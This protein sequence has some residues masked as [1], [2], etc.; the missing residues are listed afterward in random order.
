V[1]VQGRGLRYSTVV[2]IF[3]RLVRAMGIHQG[4][5]YQGP[6]IHDLRHSFAVRVLETSSTMTCPIDMGAQ[7]LALSTYL[8]HAELA[9]TYWYIHATPHL[10]TE[11]AE[12]SEGYMKGETP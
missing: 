5:G 8:G 10:L 3:L 1:S 2:G 12:V 6:R 7:M 4:A 11:I 9:S